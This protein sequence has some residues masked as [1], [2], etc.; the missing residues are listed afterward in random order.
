MHFL[1]VEQVTDRAGSVPKSTV[2]PPGAVLKFD[3]WMVTG[4]DESSGPLVGVIRFICVMGLADAEASG[5]QMANARHAAP[6]T[7]VIRIVTRRISFSFDAA[8]GTGFSGWIC[9]C[10]LREHPVAPLEPL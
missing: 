5:P 10:I 4:I 8:L 2:V 6:I 9:C 1:V 7:A 3:P